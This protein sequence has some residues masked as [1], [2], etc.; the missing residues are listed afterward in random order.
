MAVGDG[1]QKWL[2]ARLPDGTEKV[3]TFDQFNPATMTALDR[4]SPVGL[5]A[6]SRQ[7]P[8]DDLALAEPSMRSLA[9]DQSADR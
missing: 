4:P 1:V 3:I 8:I 9:P 5:A 7:Q 6:A 2:W